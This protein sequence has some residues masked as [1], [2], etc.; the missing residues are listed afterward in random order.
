MPHRRVELVRRG[1]STSAPQLLTSE[2]SRVESFWA[3]AAGELRRFER[4]RESA[5]SFE[6]PIE[7]PTKNT[8]RGTREKARAALSDALENDTLARWARERT[9]WPKPRADIALDLRVETTSRNPPRVDSVCKWL[10]DELA[11]KVYA[12]DRQV[13]LL[14]AGISRVRTVA[15][16]LTAFWGH[17][18]PARAP[19]ESHG[20]S[21]DITA[22]PR[23][24]VLADL[25]A[26]NRLDERWRFNKADFGIRRRSTGSDDIERDL[27]V[28]YQ[29]SFDP[30]DES[31][32]VQIAQ[33]GRQIDYR[34]QTSQQ[35]FVDLIF[36]Y[37]FTEL[38]VDRFGFSRRVSQYLHT[39]PYIFDVGVLPGHGQSAN[40]ERR[41]RD[42][43]IARRDRYPGLFPL[44]ARSGISMILFDDPIRSKDLDN[45]VMQTLPAV[46]DILRPPR[47]DRPGWI[48]EEPDLSLGT[49]DIPFLEVAAIPAAQS[50]MPPGS[51]VM[52]LS[53]GDRYRSWWSLVSGW[54]QSSLEESDRR[55]GW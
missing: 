54:L 33:I 6:V 3:S 12:D 53:A 13:K 2:N 1:K 16:D 18:A 49:V 5:L 45:L 8:R 50:D 27:L 7:A 15:E 39:C 29:S 51:L 55:G 21:I 44:R 42:M 43:L 14:F 32:L 46:L 10:L 23:T 11:G 9:T 35:D 40:F 31:D 41:F 48:A 38:P 19:R 25:R 4:R 17:D 34:D 22:Q 26:A 52:G 37:L 28:D 20:P 47:Q 30:A 36:S 24:A